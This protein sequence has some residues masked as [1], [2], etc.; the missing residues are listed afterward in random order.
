V[1]PQA[2]SIWPLRVEFHWETTPRALPSP[3]SGISALGLLAP[4]LRD[5]VGDL[6]VTDARSRLPGERSHESNRLNHAEALWSPALQGQVIAALLASTQ[7]KMAKKVRTR[8]TR[9]DSKRTT[10]NCERTSIPEPVGADLDPR[11][12]RRLL[13]GLT[14]VVRIHLSGFTNAQTSTGHESSPPAVAGP[15]AIMAL[16]QNGLHW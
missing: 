16:I 4:E 10:T 15:A 1:V 8:R 7:S 13:R 11:L 6:L 12:S 5:T 14:K 3:V 9:T 2:T